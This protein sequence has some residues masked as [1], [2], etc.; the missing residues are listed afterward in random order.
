MPVINHTFLDIH[1]IATRGS[2]NLSMKIGGN[3]ISGNAQRIRLRYLC[4][5][6]IALMTLRYSRVSIYTVSINIHRER[7]QMSD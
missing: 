3:G 2:L 1:K 5:S 6:M 7:S 4:Q